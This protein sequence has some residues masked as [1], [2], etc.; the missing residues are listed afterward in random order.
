MGKKYLVVDDTTSVD[1]KDGLLTGR[2]GCFHMMKFQIHNMDER[3]FVDG[4]GKRGHVLNGGM[5]LDGEEF[6]TAITRYLE[7]LGYSVRRVNRDHPD[8]DAKPFLANPVDIVASGYEW[9]CP[10]CGS[11]NT[12]IEYNP[13][14]QCYLCHKIFVAGV[15]WPAEG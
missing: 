6:R 11:L 2:N 1:C 7:A 14:V 15:P 9:I 5:V 13:R 3:V 12:E 4:V 10:K 8:N